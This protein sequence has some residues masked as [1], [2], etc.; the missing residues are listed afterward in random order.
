MNDLG[1]SCN[2]GANGDEMAGDDMTGDEMANS[3]PAYDLGG[4]AGF[5]AAAFD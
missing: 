4:T 1:E 3:A 2:D 5:A